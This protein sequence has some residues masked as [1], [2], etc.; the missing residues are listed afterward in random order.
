MLML[1]T[2]R[3]VINPE[4]VDKNF[5][6]KITVD[7]VR[8][9]LDAED[10]EQEDVFESDPDDEDTEEELLFFINGEDDEDCDED[11][12]VGDKYFF[13]LLFSIVF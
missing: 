10:R 7:E 8:E 2:R 1:L 9:H 6:E 12:E 3:E 11:E 4:K 5:F 13:C